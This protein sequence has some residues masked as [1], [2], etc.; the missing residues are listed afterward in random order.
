[1]STEGQRRRRGRGGRAARLEKNVDSVDTWAERL[2]PSD[3]ILILACGALGQ[4][5][6]N[7][8]R[9]NGWTHIKTRYFPAKLHNSPEQIA[10]LL[11][12]NIRNAESKFSQIFIG[13]ADCG[14]GGKIDS[15]LEEFGIQRLPGAHCYEFYS[16]TP[17]FEK[18]VEDEIGCYFLTDF[19]VKG[20]EKL[21]WEGLKLNLY[22]ELLETYF[23]HYKKLVYLAQTDNPELQEKA[24]EIA[25]RLDLEYVYHSTGYGDLEK[26]I[27]TL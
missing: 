24:K 15:M 26:A 10:D 21:I 14:T 6:T 8:I 25:E 2:E 12:Q 27:C 5:I 7:L 4:E 23:G 22:P 19:L 1:M 18:I 16:G 9:V 11:E 17:E 3:K 20:F 13:Y